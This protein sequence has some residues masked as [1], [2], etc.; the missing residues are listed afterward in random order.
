MSNSTGWTGCDRERDRVHSESFGRTPIPM[1][2]FASC[3][4]RWPLGAE[5]IDS[6]VKDWRKVR[7]VDFAIDSVAG[8]AVL[9]FTRKNAGRARRST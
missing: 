3:E 8:D 5:R 1:C 9:S 4:V 2:G 7:D 6:P